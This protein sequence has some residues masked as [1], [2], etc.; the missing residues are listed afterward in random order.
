MTTSSGAANEADTCGHCGHGTAAILPD[1]TMTPCVFTRAAAAGSLHE[2]AF[3]EIVAG[4]GFA[5]QV[6]R[7]DELRRPSVP[8]PMAPCVPNMCNPQCGPNCS[9]SCNP[10]GCTPDSTCGP[11][12]QCQP[13]Y[14]CGPC[15]PQDRACNPELSCRPNKR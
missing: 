8:I 6:A 13:K 9:P 14:T 4:E 12:N 2:G 3:N 11:S 5:R 15:A 7:L 1:G 10:T